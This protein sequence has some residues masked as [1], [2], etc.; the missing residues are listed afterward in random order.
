MTKKFSY[1]LLLLAAAMLF[2]GTAWGAE[3]VVT[4]TGTTSW[5]LTSTAL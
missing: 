3:E 1:P 4:D 5:M 2:S